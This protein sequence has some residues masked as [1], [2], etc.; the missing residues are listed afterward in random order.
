MKPFIQCVFTITPLICSYQFLFFIK[1]IKLA[2]NLHACPIDVAEYLSPSKWQSLIAILSQWI[3]LFGFIHYFGFSEPVKYFDTKE[4]VFIYENCD[5]CRHFLKNTN[6]RQSRQLFERCFNYGYRS[7]T[8]MASLNISTSLVKLFCSGFFLIN[9]TWIYW[10]FASRF[11]FVEI[12]HEHF[13][14]LYQS[15]LKWF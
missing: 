4:L 7:S 10:L 8:K 15:A 5:N 6:S 14:F 9:S 1:S 12:L 3:L 2:L 13:G 11:S